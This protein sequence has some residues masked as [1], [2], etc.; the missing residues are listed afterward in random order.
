MSLT[1][2]LATERDEREGRIR[3]TLYDLFLEGKADG[4][5]GKKAIY[6]DP[7]Y[8]EGYVAGLK[9]L[10]S[11]EA[12]GEIQYGNPYKHFAFGFLDTPD[13]TTYNG[14]FDEF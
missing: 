5:F 10:P 12:T 1:D 3:D 4:A 6:A 2:Y 13:P 11:D 9:E 14:G 8:L 7:T